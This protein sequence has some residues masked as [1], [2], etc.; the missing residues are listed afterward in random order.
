MN[1]DYTDI[2]LLNGDRVGSVIAQTQ[3]RTNSLT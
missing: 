2:V 3:N 1:T